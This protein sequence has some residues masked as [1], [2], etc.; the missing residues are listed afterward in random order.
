MYDGCGPLVAGVRGLAC[1]DV[2]GGF[3]V[4]MK[5][6]L[7][8]TIINNQVC[9]MTSES[10]HRTSLSVNPSARSNILCVFYEL[11]PELSDHCKTA[12]KT[13]AILDNSLMLPSQT[14]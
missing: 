12:E 14:A 1:L 8:S 4:L 11:P 7:A 10:T 2:L 6:N 3:C 5:G 9:G 13:F